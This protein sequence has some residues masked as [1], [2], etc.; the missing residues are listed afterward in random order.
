MDKGD[1]KSETTITP[2]SPKQTRVA[3]PKP[4]F[5]RIYEH[6]YSVRGSVHQGIQNFAP[7]KGGD[8]L[9]GDHDRYES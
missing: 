8:S 4:A 6:D 1:I 5:G 7:Q 9:I 2:D 3:M